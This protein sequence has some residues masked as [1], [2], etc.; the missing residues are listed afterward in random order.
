MKVKQTIE[1]FQS[2]AIHSFHAHLQVSKYFRTT[3]S[4]LYKIT[5]LALSYCV[6]EINLKSFL[7]LNSY[8][9]FCSHMKN[10]ERSSSKPQ[11]NLA[12][13]TTCSNR[14]TSLPFLHNKTYSIPPS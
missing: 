5:V 14:S 7:K 9:Q 12:T 3:D 4:L 11:E 6:K 2:W 1:I 8:L 13:A 10:P